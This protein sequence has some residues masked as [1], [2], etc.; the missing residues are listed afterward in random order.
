M[1]ASA[2]EC[3][4]RL[5]DGKHLALLKGFVHIDGNDGRKEVRNVRPAH[6]LYRTQSSESCCSYVI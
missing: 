3:N 2:C 6:D 5:I 4:D 1:S